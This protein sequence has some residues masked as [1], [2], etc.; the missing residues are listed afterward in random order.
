M[1]FCGGNSPVLYY[2]NF[3]FGIV[4]VDGRSEKKTYTHMKRS[5]TLTILLAALLMLPALSNA[6]R[7][8]PWQLGANIG[9]TWQTSDVE[10]YAHLGWGLTLTKWTHQNQTNHFDYGFRFRYLNGRTYGR[11]YKRSEGLRSNSIFNGSS[12]TTLNYAQD[13]GYI[14]H[15]Y[16]MTVDEFS[17]EFLLGLNRLRDRTGVMIYGWGGLGVAG[18]QTFTDQRDFTGLKYNYTNI[19]STGNKAS[20]DDALKTLRDGEYETA[21]EGSQTRNWSFSPSAGIG[22]GYQ[23]T[24]GFSI[25]LE[26]KTT[27]PR[28]DILDGQQWNNAGNKTAANDRYHYGGLHLLFA[29]GGGKPKEMVKTNQDNYS[30]GTTVVNN[31]PLPTNPVVGGGGGNNNPGNTG[32][33]GTVNNYSPQPDVRFLNPSYTPYNSQQEALQVSAKVEHT[34]SP[35]NVS[36]RFNGYSVNN[37][38]YNSATEVV[39]FNVN[40]IP[41]NNTIE[42]KATNNVGSDSESMTVVYSNPN[43]YSSAPPVVTITYPNGNPFNSTQNNVAVN[44]TVINVTAKNQIAV[45]VN[46]S[47]VSNFNYDSYTKVINFNAS[48]IAGNNTVVISATTPGGS[49]SKFLNINYRPDTPPSVLKPVVTFINPASNPITSQVAAAPISAKVENVQSRNN[50]TV[51][52]NSVPVSSFNYDANTKILTMTANLVTGA[53]VISITGTNTAGSDTKSTTLMYKP[54]SVQRPVVTIITPGTNPFTYAV[55]SATV[56]ATVLNVSSSNEISVMLDGVPVQPFNYNMNT[57]QLTFNVSLKP[58][59]NNVMIN[60]SNTAGSDTKSTVLVYKQPG[61]TVSAPDVKIGSPK[62]NPHTVTAPA[63]TLTASVKNAARK[64]LAVTVN[65]TP[66]FNYT[67]AGGTVTL[68]LTLTEGNT[69]VVITATNSAGTSSDTRTLVYAPV[70][71]PMVQLMEPSISNPRQGETIIVTGRVFNVT[72]KSQVTVK[73]NGNIMS[74][75]TYSET[76]KISLSPVLLAGSNVFEVTATTPGGTDTKSITVTVPGPQTGNQNQQNQQNNI[77]PGGG[78]GN[79]KVTTKPSSGKPGKGTSAPSG[80]GGSGTTNTKTNTKTNTETEKDTNSTIPGKG[81]T[82]TAPAGKSGKTTVTPTGKG[83]PK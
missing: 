76:G 43:N 40:L 51:T 17:L 83:S 56:N 11:D 28:V 80:K 77:T 37:F 44:G 14:F 5:F 29:I 64:E 16:K 60:A 39:T 47:P 24:P 46:G 63:F 7:Y 69:T 30:T 12:D 20:V 26:Y 48:L 66:V 35:G 25:A 45:S 15:N 75:W 27:F 68:P 62:S 13:P 49:D 2:V 72:S 4:R 6:Q 59:S 52:L 19:D 78:K 23:F 31:N 10:D 8:N 73:H 41:G 57:K 67:F 18:W 36:I 9:G 22:F 61:P 71:A 3:Y 33:T 82:T 58:G 50:I 55:S 21:A 81:G 38:N 34:S 65:N 70:P 42:V 54:A 53:N 32:N 79:P 74:T 1:P